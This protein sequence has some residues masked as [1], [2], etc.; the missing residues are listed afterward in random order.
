MPPQRPD[1][2]DPLD[3]LAFL[4][5][6]SQRI[7]ALTGAGVSAESGVP[8]FRDAQSGLWAKYNPK[9]LATPDAYRRDPVLVTRWYDWRR[10]TL[11]TCRPNPGHAAL[12]SLQRATRSRAATFTLITQNIDRLHHEAGSQDVIEL[13]GSI[14]TWRCDDCGAEAE[15]R[16]VPFESHPPTCDECGGPRRPGVVWFGESLPEAAIEAAVSAASGCDL[17]LSIGTSST[18]SPASSLIELARQ[19]RAHTVEINPA[20]T[21]ETDLVDLVIAAPSGEALPDALRRAGIDNQA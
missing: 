9:Q 1:A 5:T 20:P 3:A 11:A 17:F 4:L 18:V 19:S 10:E 8:T 15:E 14:W 16:T 6:K 2:I 12:A 7:V 21:P 13:H